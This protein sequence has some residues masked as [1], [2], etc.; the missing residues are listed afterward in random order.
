MAGKGGWTRFRLSWAQAGALLGGHLWGQNHN[1]FSTGGDSASL[2]GHKAESGD[3]SDRRS[4]DML[5]SSQ[6]KPPVPRAQPQM[7][8]EP[9]GEM[10]VA[11]SKGGKPT[12]LVGPVWEALFLSS[13]LFSGW[14][15]LEGRAHGAILPEPLLTRSRV[16]PAYP[17]GPKT[18]RPV[19]GWGPVSCHTHLLNDSSDVEAVIAQRG[20]LGVCSAKATGARGC[21]ERP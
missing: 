17:V 16:C 5:S 3:I 20:G 19:R 6:E 12:H 4:W 11:D 8:A 2:R 10:L 9:N 21:G 7:S 1:V 13:G 18:R 15:V 14:S